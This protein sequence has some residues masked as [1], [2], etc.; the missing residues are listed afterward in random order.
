MNTLNKL[1]YLD[2]HATTP[3]DK[4]VLE[5]M[6]PYFT[7]EFG[8]AASKTHW[9]G[10]KAEK[11]VSKARRQLANN[12]NA[13]EKEI[14][15]TS[16]ATES[17]NMAIKGVFNTLG[18][19]KNHFITAAT[20]HYAVLDCHGY[21]RSK[22]AQVTTLP[23]NA[24]GLVSLDHI[25]SAITDRTALVSVMFA[26][27]EIGTVQPV[28]EIAKLC[29]EKGVLFFTD[30]TQALG[31]VPINVKQLPIDMLACSSHKVYGPKGVGLLYVKKSRP[32]IKLDPLIHGGGHE[33]GM[34]SGTLNIPGIVGFA[35]AVDISCHGM[36]EEM[37]K[38]QD[39]RDYLQDRLISELPDVIINGDKENRLSNN[40]NIAFLGV[41]AEALMLSL[42][43]EIAVSSGS[44]CTSEEFKPSHVLK[45]LGLEDDIIFSSIRFSLGRYTTE[46]EIEYSANRVIDEVQ[47]LREMSI[48]YTELKDRYK[49]RIA[50][51]HLSNFK[52]TQTTAKFGA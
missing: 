8:N 37:D 39:L 16:G 25:K 28:S 5:E 33:R 20:E 34:R 24:D 48:N 44:A 26:N 1:I 31:K 21:I 27:N 15:F 7:V 19:K 6:L 38:I 45:A 12:L 51:G 2:Y 18:T 36:V 43:N 46:N 52:S 17:I 50:V 35:K 41:E 40:L 47:R 32:R 10:L 49:S 4:R 9:Y 13:E 3:V 29:Q 22:G 30:A 11:A 14:F 42:K 23:V